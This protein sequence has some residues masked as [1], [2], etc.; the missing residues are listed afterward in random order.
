MIELYKITSRKYDTSAGDFLKMRDETVLRKGGRGNSKK[1]LTQRANLEVRRNSFCLR[2]A[3]IWNSLPEDVISAK[4]LNT[5]KNRL[6]KYWEGQEVKF[7]NYRAS[8]TTGSHKFKLQDES[9][10]EDLTEPALE[11]NAK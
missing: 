11:N 6:D 1:I 2:S 8:I 7:D 5:F 4:T 9:S 10:K 3:A